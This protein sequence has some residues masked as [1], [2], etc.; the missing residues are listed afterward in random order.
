MK[1]Y[2]LKRVYLPTEAVGS[3]YD[4]SG[5]LIC[6]TLELPWKDNQRS[7]SCIPEGTYRVIKQEPKESRPYPYFHLPEVRGRSGILIHKITYVK[8][9]K[10]CIGVGGRHVDI[11]KDGVPDIADSTSKLKWMT[12]NLPDTFELV[13]S[14][15]DK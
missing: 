10:G 11:D 15:R 4:E 12:D 7:I 1:R 13:I 3:I 6:K 9:L 5:V 14:N 8:D 2:F